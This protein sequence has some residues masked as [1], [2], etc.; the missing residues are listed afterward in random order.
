[1][2]IISDRQIVGRYFSDGMKFKNKEDVRLQLIDF[3]SIDCD[4]IS[5]LRK[6]ELWEILDY[7]QWTIE[8]V[9]PT[10]GA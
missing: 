7:G 5:T 2:Y 10:K 9:T 3:H 6:M 1:M 4:E 8:K